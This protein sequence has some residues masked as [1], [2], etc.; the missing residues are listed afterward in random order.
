MKWMRISLFRSSAK[1]FLKATS[2]LGLRN[3]LIAIGINEINR[4]LLETK[5]IVFWVLYISKIDGKLPGTRS[6]VCREQMSDEVM[7]QL[8]I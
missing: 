5:M 2:F 7:P 4:R 6:D 8:F 3:L 1:T